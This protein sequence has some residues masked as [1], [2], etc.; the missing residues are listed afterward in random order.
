MYR[1]LLPIVQQ[2]LGDSHETTCSCK[3]GLA[4]TFYMQGQNS[5]SEQLHRETLEARRRVLGPED[6]NTLKSMNGLAGPLID[7]QRHAEAEELYREMIEIQRRV[8]GDEQLRQQSE[9]LPRPSGT[10]ARRRRETA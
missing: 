4:W 6:P 7:L 10:D 3:W 5:E 9:L 8:S 1:Q 2:S